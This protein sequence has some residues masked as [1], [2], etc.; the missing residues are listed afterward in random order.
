[1]FLIISKNQFSL[2]MKKIFAPAFLV[3]S[4]FLLTGCPVGVTYPLAKPNSRPIDKGLIGTWVTDDEEATILEVS[5]KKASG[6][7]YTV[8]VLEKGESYMVEEDIFTGWVTELG[9]QKFVF[10]KAK[11]SDKYFHYR[12]EIKGKNITVW[13]VSL[14]DG[15][16][17]A[18]TSTEA[19]QKEV[20]ASMKM[21]GWSKE[22]TTYY[23]Q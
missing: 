2:K 6:T 14:L 8:S 16:M 23:K 18:I 3:L 12:Y 20:L 11:G 13:D 7:S 22:P 5:I 9:G 10:L 19:F 4:L 21:E 15:G 17:D 1:M